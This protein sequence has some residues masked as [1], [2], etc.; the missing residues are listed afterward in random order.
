[1]DEI[2]QGRST[3][4]SKKPLLIQWYN[5]KMGTVDLVD[6]LL[7]PTDPIRKSY[8]RLKK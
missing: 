1:M 3:G 7:E 6:Q 5:E 4:V 8:T 2:H